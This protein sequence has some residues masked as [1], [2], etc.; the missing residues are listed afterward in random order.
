MV[1]ALACEGACL[2]CIF[3]LIM[4]EPLSLHLQCRWV[5]ECQIQHSVIGSFQ[6]LLHLRFIVSSVLLSF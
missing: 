6:H 4:F 5:D 3:C 2:Q 1:G